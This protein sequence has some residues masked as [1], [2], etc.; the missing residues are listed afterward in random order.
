LLSEQKTFNKKIAGTWRLAPYPR[1]DS[2]IRLE[3]GED[4]SGLFVATKNNPNYEGDK[5][6]VFEDDEGNVRQMNGTSNLDKWMS[7]VEPGSVIR[8]KRLNDRKIGKPKPLQV[9]E[10]YIWD[11]QTTKSEKTN[12][13]LGGD[14]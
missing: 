12:K 13:N 8:I 2:F 4:F 6:H 10:V 5:I 1:D 7:V 3:V 14:G 11:E 9:F